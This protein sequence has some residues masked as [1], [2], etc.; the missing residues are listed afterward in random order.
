MEK[1]SFMNMGTLFVFSCGSISAQ[2]SACWL[3]ERISSDELVEVRV[4]GEIVMR[5]KRGLLGRNVVKSVRRR[6]E[7]QE[8]WPERWESENTKSEMLQ[9]TGL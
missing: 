1:V 3:K 6:G 8:E 4:V 2:S 7:D 9:C 5:E